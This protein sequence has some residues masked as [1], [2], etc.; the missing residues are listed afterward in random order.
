MPELPEVETV[1]RQLDPELTG[2]AVEAVEVLDPYFTKPDDPTGFERSAVGRTLAGVG[3]RGKYLLIEFT[4]GDTLVIHLRMTG[5]LI[6]ADRD[7][8][9]PA[10]DGRIYTPPSGAHLKARFV[11]DGDLELRFYDPRRFGRGF[12]ASPDELESYLGARLG[13]EPLSGEFTVDELARVTAGRR[14]P[15]RTRPPA[16]PTGAAHAPPSP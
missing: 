11:L 2:R 13:V 5:N 7:G 1:R 4:D 10:P 16:P 15:R 9:R 12:I 8:E 6:L 3:R 14:G